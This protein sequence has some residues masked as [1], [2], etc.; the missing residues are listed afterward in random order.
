MAVQGKFFPTMM[1][2]CAHTMSPDNSWKSVCQV[3][4]SRM[5]E[6][7]QSSDDTAARRKGQVGDCFWTQSGKVNSS[8]VGRI[9]L[10]QIPQEMCPG[11]CGLQEY[12][13]LWQPQEPFAGVLVAK[14]SEE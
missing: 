11:D 8:T 6:L 12:C 14:V 3:S 10:K 1:D 7:S 13:Q 5:G 4:R 2:M 9:G